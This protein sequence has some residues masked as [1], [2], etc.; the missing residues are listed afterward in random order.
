MDLNLA[1]NR[2]TRQSRSQSSIQIWPKSHNVSCDNSLKSSM[3][4]FPHYFLPYNLYFYNPASALRAAIIYV[5]SQVF[6]VQDT[7]EL[8]IMIANTDIKMFAPFSTF[9]DLTCEIWSSGEIKFTD[10]F[11][12]KNSWNIF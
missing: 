11:L 9:Y 8:K 6:D 5:T 2:I 10:I 7:E 3:F 12:G 1:P 4:F